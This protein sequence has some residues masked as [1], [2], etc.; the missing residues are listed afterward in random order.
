MFES[1]KFKVKVR[2]MVGVNLISYPD[3]GA[4]IN[5]KSEALMEGVGVS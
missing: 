2:S 4:P 1:Q 5:T 3:K